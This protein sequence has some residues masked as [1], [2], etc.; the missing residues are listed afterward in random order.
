MFNSH[1]KA[2]LY[3]SQRASR[4]GW[5]GVTDGEMDEK[6]EDN[7]G[8][9]DWWTVEVGRRTHKHTHLPR[10]MGG[11]RGQL[12]IDGWCGGGCSVCVCVQAYISVNVV[13]LWK[14][15]CRTFPIFLKH[16]FLYLCH[17]V[18][19]ICA[20][21]CVYFPVWVVYMCTVMGGGGHSCSTFV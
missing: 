1:F 17:P 8:R 18:N 20:E 7:G 15:V 5:W 21:M 6:E 9:G 16:I 2:A 14:S 19:V 3:G 10:G 11:S 13:L 12:G 4:G